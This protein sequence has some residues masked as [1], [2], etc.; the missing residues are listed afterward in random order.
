MSPRVRLIGYCG[1]G[2]VALFSGFLALF[3]MSGR[4]GIS[5]ILFEAAVCALAIFNLRI[6]AWSV[7]FTSE[8]EWLMSE[9]RKAELRQRLAGFGKFASDQYAVPALTGDPEVSASQPPQ[10]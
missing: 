8:E 4:Y 7:Q 10:R 1:N 2:A 6:I 9:V 5:P 3:S